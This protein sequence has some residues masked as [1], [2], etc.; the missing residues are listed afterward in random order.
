MVFLGFHVHV[1]SQVNISA[2]NTITQNFDGIGTSEEADLPAGWKADKRTS[3]QNVGTY[4]AA[5]TKTELRAGIICHLML[6][7]AFIIMERE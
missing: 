7:T 5:G 3:A 1:W 4:S 2:G 6:K